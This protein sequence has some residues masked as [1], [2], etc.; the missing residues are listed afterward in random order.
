[1]SNTAKNVLLAS[2]IADAG[3]AYARGDYEIAEALDNQA[4]ELS[5]E[6]AAETPGNGLKGLTIKDGPIEY[7]FV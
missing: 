2:L 7:V 5:N 1:M 3:A 4:E 6:I